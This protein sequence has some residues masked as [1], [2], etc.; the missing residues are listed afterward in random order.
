VRADVDDRRAEGGLDLRRLVRG[1]GD[2]LEQLEL[3]L[4]LVEQPRVLS[5]NA[6]SLA[7]TSALGIELLAEPLRL[8]RRVRHLLGAHHKLPAPWL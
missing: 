8:V 7:P 4:A 2:H 6:L 5:G 1:L 3:V